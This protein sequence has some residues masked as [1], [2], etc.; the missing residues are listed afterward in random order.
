MRARLAPRQKWGPPPPKAMWGLGSRPMSKVSGSV[1]TSSSRLADVW[2]KTT[3]SPAAILVPLSSSVAHGGAAE[4]HD[5]RDEAQHLVDGAGQE[6]AVGEEAL[7]LLGVLEEGVH[8]AGHEVAGRL[9]AGDG[10][11]QEEELELQVAEALA[12]DLDAW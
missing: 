2:K 3:L 5:G 12:L 4:V 1:K 9:V 6:A 11:E 7:P 8:G 10:E